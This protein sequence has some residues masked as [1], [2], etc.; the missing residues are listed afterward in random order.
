MRDGGHSTELH[1]TCMCESGISWQNESTALVAAG[2]LLQAYNSSDRSSLALGFSA[3]FV[4]CKPV[5]LRFA[6]DDESFTSASTPEQAYQMHV[7][8]SSLIRA[9]AA[10]SEMLPNF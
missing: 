10:G 8:W 3:Q 1:C 9:L 4:Q 5:E 6:S 2:T 7:C